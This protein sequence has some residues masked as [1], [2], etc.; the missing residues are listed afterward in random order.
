MVVMYFPVGTWSF[1]LGSLS[2]SYSVFVIKDF[3]PTRTKLLGSPHH[4]FVAVHFVCPG[5]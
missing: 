2:F 1:S 5:N 3:V 4:S